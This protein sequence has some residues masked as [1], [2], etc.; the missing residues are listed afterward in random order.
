MAI[1]LADVTAWEARLRI[2]VHRDENVRHTTPLTY[3]P[4]PRLLHPS[5][6]Y[7]P[8]FPRLRYDVRIRY[9]APLLI[10]EG[11]TFGVRRRVRAYDIRTGE[12]YGRGPLEEMLRFLVETFDDDMSAADQDV[13]AAWE[14]SSESASEPDS[15]GAVSD[16][17]DEQEL[18]LDE[19]SPS[20]DDESS[21]P[22]RSG[23]PAVPSDSRVLGDAQNTSH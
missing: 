4:D 19:D 18:T 22:P 8:P 13:Y 14:S 11:Y 16:E 7:L 5:N 10:V 6:P 1:R 12:A 3:I 23:P 9:L 15:G 20:E 21:P 2:P 17:T